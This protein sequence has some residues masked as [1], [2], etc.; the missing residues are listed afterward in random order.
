[1]SINKD[2]ITVTGVG[3]MP[4]MTGKVCAQKGIIVTAAKN[5][6]IKNLELYGATNNVNLA[7]IRHDAAGL[8]L[9]LDNV[10]IHDNDDGILGGKLGDTI[11]IQ[12]SRFE[13]NG[14]NDSSGY[15]HNLYI[16]EATS[17]TFKNSQSLR[18]KLGGHEIK[19]RAY[20][21]VIDSSVVATLD[22]DDSR[23]L[24]ACEGGELIIRN[25]VFQKSPSSENSAFIAFAAESF[26]SRLHSVTMDTNNIFLDD[27]GGGTGVQFFHVPATISITG[28]TFVDIGGI[29]S[30]GTP[31]SNQT[32]SSR[33]AAGYQAYP[34][35]P[36]PN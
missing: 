31:V 29:A 34:W 23:A 2:N 32:Y 5:A 8:N 4:A 33:S 11:L 25:S 9:T 7:G 6:V 13:K 36:T 21:T 16:G 14:M 22:G 20:K 18:A 10:Y 19:T 28:N 27:R 24:D 17:F 30:A 35:L 1:M 3:G 26:D 12:N 15:A